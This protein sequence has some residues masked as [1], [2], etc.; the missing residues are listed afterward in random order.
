[1]SALFFVPSSPY[2]VFPLVITSIAWRGVAW[3]LGALGDASGWACATSR[4]RDVMYLNQYRRG[5]DTGANCIQGRENNTIYI[6]HQR[7]FYSSI[8]KQTDMYPV[9]DSLPSPGERGWWEISDKNSGGISTSAL[10]VV[11]MYIYKSALSTTPSKIPSMTEKTP[12]FSTPRLASPRSTE[13]R[14]KKKTQRGG[15]LYMED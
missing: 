5:N 8:G 12:F 1:M 6:Q 9:P 2:S 11:V 10:P 4:R 7:C 3:R 15:V 13:E 14:E